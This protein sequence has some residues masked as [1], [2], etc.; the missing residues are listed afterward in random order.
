LKYSDQQLGT[1][2]DI[3][4]VYRSRPVVTVADANRVLDKHGLG[5]ALAVEALGPYVINF[6]YKVIRPGAPPLVLKGQY[7]STMAWDVA[8]EAEA[9]RLLREGT[10][11]PVP[12][13]AI[14]DGQCDA[15]PSP[16]VLID[17]LEGRSSL[18]IYERGDSDQRCR[19][20]EQHGAIHHAIHTCPLPTAPTLP[21][22]DLRDWR[23]LAL[24]LLFAGDDLHEA[25]G[26][27]CPEFEHEIRSRLD[28]AHDIPPIG[29]PVLSW[30]DGSLGN[31]MARLDDDGSA[32]ICGVFDLQS[33]ILMQ[34]RWD[35]A[36]AFN[37]FV[38]GAAPDREATPEW[39]A[40]C[41]GYGGDDHLDGSE[42]EAFGVVFPALHVRHWWEAMH[43]LHPQTPKWLDDLLEG[44]NRL[45]D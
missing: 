2:D 9:I 45:A 25:L 35:L 38:P 1:M 33:A 32:R 11:L 39:H 12:G 6:I 27:L 43:F 31:T 30:R 21:V 29:P 24:Q 10:D 36:R 13:S 7:L 3:R 42:T 20:A 22:I 41:Q 16:Y 18:E 34:R 15:L 14:Y 5:S 40:F 28:A 44:L 4:A 19:L 26:Q 17:W 8:Q 37:S 23:V